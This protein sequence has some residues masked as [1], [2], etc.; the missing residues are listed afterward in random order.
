M[1]PTINSLSYKRGGCG[2]YFLADD[3]VSEWTIALL[4]SLHAY[5][6]KSSIWCIPFSEEIS[7][8]KRLAAH[9]GFGIYDDPSLFE[10]DNIGHSLLPD[11][12][13]IAGKFR[14]LAA[15]WGPLEH[16]IYLDADTVILGDVE[17]LFTTLLTTNYDLLYADSNLDMVYKP[18]AFRD[19]M[20]REYQTHGFV[21]GVWASTVGQLSLAEIRMFA[22]EVAPDVD[23][24]ATTGEQPFVNYCIDRKRTRMR[25]FASA[26]DHRIY[27]NWPGQ[28]ERLYVSTLDESRIRVYTD[29]WQLVSGVH[30]AGFS[31]DP[32]MPHYKIY[33][34]F[35]LRSSTRVE[36]VKWNVKRWVRI[37]ARRLR[38]RTVGRRLLTLSRRLARHLRIRRL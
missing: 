24:F 6:P 18:G 4:N 12:G 22:A 29:R 31:L 3:F 32:Q 7:R 5:A 13:R 14:R 25:S 11:I 28:A 36:R 33:Q 27:W 2:V 23:G 35:R 1:H 16:F 19:R 34:H 30:W 8:L 26:S 38:L 17:P 10:L 20:V 9:F 21:T 37:L 15:F